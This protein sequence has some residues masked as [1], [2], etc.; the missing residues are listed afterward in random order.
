LGRERQVKLLEIRW[1]SGGMQTW[2][3][4]AANQIFVAKEASQ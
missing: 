4:V 2:K 3:N 1:P